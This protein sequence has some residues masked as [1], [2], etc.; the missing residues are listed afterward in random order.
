LKTSAAF[1]WKK[2]PALHVGGFGVSGDV[3]LSRA[4]AAV[5]TMPIYPG[6]Q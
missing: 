1:A 4:L 2:S 5:A 6:A 3:P